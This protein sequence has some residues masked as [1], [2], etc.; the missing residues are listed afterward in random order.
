MF[1]PEFCLLKYQYFTH[2]D[3]SAHHV[4]SESVSILVVTHFL[5]RLADSLSHQLF[6]Y[7]P[8]KIKQQN[9]QGTSQTG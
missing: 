9:E 5:D 1:S 4:W 2:C 8:A 7:R 6:R 3:L